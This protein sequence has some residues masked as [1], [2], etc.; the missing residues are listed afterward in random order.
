MREATVRIL[1]KVDPPDVRRIELILVD[2][3]QE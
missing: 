3:Q 2:V 1:R